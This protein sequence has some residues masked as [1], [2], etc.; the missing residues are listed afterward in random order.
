MDEEFLKRFTDYKCA[1][2]GPSPNPNSSMASGELPNRDPI[3]PPQQPPQ[4]RPLS[5]DNL[6]VS[7]N[8]Q[9]VMQSKDNP[10][11]NQSPRKILTNKRAFTSQLQRNAFPITDAHDDSPPQH[12][13]EMR[14]SDC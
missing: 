9:R 8:Y 5:Q 7:Q 1:G 11:K 13:A 4:P 10:K 14:S 6:S 3:N 12:F 2:P